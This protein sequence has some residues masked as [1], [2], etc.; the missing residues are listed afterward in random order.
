M[1]E[2]DSAAVIEN[3]AGNHIHL[4]QYNTTQ[5]NS[6]YNM[7]HLYTTNRQMCS[8][9][10][11]SSSRID[12][13]EIILWLVSIA[14]KRFTNGTFPIDLHSFGNFGHYFFG[15]ILVFIAVCAIYWDCVKSNHTSPCGFEFK[16]IGVCFV[17]V[18]TAVITLINV[19]LMGTI[20]GTLERV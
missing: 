2:R 10:Q 14:N 12:K 15:F 9:V 13:I 8:T 5:F 17:F 11:S 4:R 20:K 3:R 19:Y 18:C 16:L 7:Y 6:V 1:A